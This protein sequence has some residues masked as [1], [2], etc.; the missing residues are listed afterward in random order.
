MMCALGIKAPT[1]AESRG[2]E[3]RQLLSGLALTRI[4]DPRLR[5]HGQHALYEELNEMMKELNEIIIKSEFTQQAVDK[6]VSLGRML[7][8]GRSFLI[9][10]YFEETIERKLTFI[11][12]SVKWLAEKQ[13]SDEQLVA[14]E[15]VKEELRR[16]TPVCISKADT[17]LLM[18]LL[19][20]QL[21]C[22][23]E[24]VHS[25]ER[26]KAGLAPI[27]KE[28]KEVLSEYSEFF[29]ELEEKPLSGELD[30]A[31]I[32]MLEELLS[33]DGR[34]LRG[35]PV[36]YSSL[37]API[38]ENSDN[39]EE[40][41][42]YALRSALLDSS[43]HY[44]LTKILEILEKRCGGVR[45]L[46]SEL[47]FLQRSER[48]PPGALTGDPVRV[49]ARVTDETL[50]QEGEKLRR[51]GQYAL[52]RELN[53]LI[54]E[55]KQIIIEP[56]SI[57]DPID[58][59]KSLH[60]RLDFGR[61]FLSYAPW[62]S[63]ETSIALDSSLIIKYVNNWKV[64]QDGL[65]SDEFSHEGVKK[66]LRA[67]TPILLSKADTLLLTG[68]AICSL[69]SS[70]FKKRCKVMLVLV[71]KELK[72]A[73]SEHAALF[74]E[75]EKKLSYGKLDGANVNMLSNLLSPNGIVLSKYFT[76]TS[77]NAIIMQIEDPVKALK[78]WEGW[79]LGSAT[80]Y[81]VSKLELILEEEGVI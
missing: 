80:S 57:R 2:G 26:C 30:K 71:F 53:Y 40:E 3:V 58:E 32:S 16:F 1:L 47:T 50:E 12:E 7:S 18:M 68:E 24:S 70:R 39:L 27:F 41:V 15:K 55:L 65:P 6:M 72:E 66:K 4:A 10:G 9:E 77:L 73:L 19:R 38:A 74:A 60:E 21:L 69:Q 59:I 62:D 67:S 42:P 78:A 45:R 31:D 64:T 23:L 49:P 44:S 28:L 34:I 48:F 22:S 36:L 43:I 79:F 20:D 11:I 63:A 8:A 54:N 81:S 17:L 33:P 35:Y 56:K 51:Y 52:Y 75:L 37:I 13:L 25:K 5:K 61:S 14:H 46:V 29:A 76:L